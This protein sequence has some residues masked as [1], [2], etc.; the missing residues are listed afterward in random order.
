MPP[1]IKLIVEN[2]LSNYGRPPEGR[3]YST[4]IKVWALSINFISP[5][6]LRFLK[7]SLDPPSETTLRSFIS[8]WPKSPGNINFNVK[9]L[10]LKMN[11]SQLPNIYKYCSISADEMSLQV[12]LDYNRKR[13]LFD[14]L[15]D[16]GEDE[17][18][19]SYPATSA[20]V[21]MA[22]GIAKRCKHPLAYFFVR[23]TRFPVA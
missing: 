10:S 13:D 20:L 19:S 2:H 17:S 8:T 21:I 12:H 15:E 14:G 6:A 22:Q 4:G 5:K 9:S 16:F 18:R 3:R 23:H 11:E 7:S 1:D